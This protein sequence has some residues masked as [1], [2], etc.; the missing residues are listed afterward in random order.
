MYKVFDIIW[1][2][3]NLFIVNGE[4]KEVE[5][6]IR[7][8]AFVSNPNEQ[9]PRNNCA[10]ANIYNTNNYTVGGINAYVCLCNNKEFCNG[11]SALHMSAMLLGLLGFLATIC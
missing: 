11:S 4:I 1:I 3:L 6:V 8:C 2:N 10:Y 7:S 9:D 5:A